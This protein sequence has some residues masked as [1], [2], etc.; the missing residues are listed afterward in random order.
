MQDCSST[1]GGRA[2]LQAAVSG[3][4]RKKRRSLGMA[5]EENNVLVWFVFL[6]VGLF[7]EIKQFI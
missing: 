2:L 4:C 5:W 3:L 7:V 6:G 1:A